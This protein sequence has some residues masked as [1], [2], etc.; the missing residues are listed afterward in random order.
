MLLSTPD[1][2]AM[3][4]LSKIR[5]ARNHQKSVACQNRIFDTK[6]SKQQKIMVFR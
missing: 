6:Y 1:I 5:S 3:T 4:T 2:P